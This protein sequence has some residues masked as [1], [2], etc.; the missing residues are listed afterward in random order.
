MND[1]IDALVSRVRASALPTGA[2][3]RTLAQLARSQPDAA[4]RVR[5]AAASDTP[6]RRFTALCT[7][8]D[9]A[10]EK[11]ARAA[12]DQL[13][14]Y[15]T[16]Y[17]VASLDSAAAHAFAHRVAERALWTFLV[18][19][20]AR[21]VA[22]RDG[23]K[24]SL[25]TREVSLA[26]DVF[27][28]TLGECIVRSACGA[29]ICSVSLPAGTIDVATLDAWAQALASSVVF[30]VSATKHVLEVL[31]ALLH[32]RLDSLAIDDAI[33]A[34]E[35]VVF[36][37]LYAAGWRG[38]EVA[39]GAAWRAG[40]ARRACFL[41]ALVGARGGER[42]H[43]VRRSPWNARCRE[44]IESDVRRC[45]ALR[46]LH[47]QFRREPELLPALRAPLDAA[48]AALLAAAAERA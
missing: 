36:A 24:P 8:C 3:V 32:G 25:L 10:D 20:R 13:A 23:M 4:A 37:W 38:V 29:E 22:R 9:S 33:L 15:S 48:R 45:N 40:H 39:E 42:A 7:L 11:G 30:A 2:D 41:A 43:E 18:Q 28:R 34:N 16:V 17:I 47:A 12:A 26:L 5:A 46:Q 21:A 6:D 31:D 35:M 19:R 27:G 1:G 44:R 14:P